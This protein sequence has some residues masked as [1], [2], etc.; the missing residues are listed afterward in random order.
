M[1]VDD[2]LW[3]AE[4]VLDRWGPGGP[5]LGLFAPGGLGMSAGMDASAAQ[6]AGQLNR[7]VAQEDASEQARDARSRALEAMG[8]Q[9]MFFG[10]VVKL[11]DVSRAVMVVSTPDAFVLLDADTNADPTGELA[12][13]PKSD[14]A[15]VRLVDA[16]GNEVADA[17][18]DPI[19]EL[20]TPGDDRY[21]VVLE[22]ADGSGKSVSFLFLS[23]EPALFAKTRFL[24]L[25]KQT[26]AG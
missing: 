21:G 6:V 22:R 10:G 26:Q 5:G 4:R 19:R 24:E 13:I 23:G 15:H 8:S 2:W 16:N 18:I 12:R 7:L 25:L 1:G 3:E 20:D 17:A 14:V 9:G 11:G